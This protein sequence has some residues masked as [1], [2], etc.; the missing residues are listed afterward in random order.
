MAKR[1]LRVLEWLSS[2]PVTGVCAACLKVFKV[3]MV[4]L[5]RTKDAQENMQQQ[6]DA[7][8]CRHEDERTSAASVR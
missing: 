2:T 3:P 4:A 6:F 1:N 7:H 5:S 8:K